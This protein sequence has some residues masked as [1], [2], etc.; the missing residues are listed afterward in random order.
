MNQCVLRKNH[1]VIPNPCLKQEDY[2]ELIEQF[3]NILNELMGIVPKDKRILVIELEDLK[4]RTEY[5]ATRKSF[6]KGFKMAKQLKR[7]NS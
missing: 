3:D 5:I 6:C 7:L 4:G 1:A 2:M